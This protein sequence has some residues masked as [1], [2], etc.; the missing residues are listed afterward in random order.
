MLTENNFEEIGKRLRD[1]EADPPVEG[2]NKIRRELHPA[3]R[4][5]GAFFKRH[6]WKGLLLLVPVIT[7]FALTNIRSTPSEK[8]STVSSANE[9]TQ[10]E[11]NP[12][13]AAD[14]QS[15]NTITLD[16][17]ERDLLSDKAE[18]NATTSDQTRKSVTSE[19]KVAANERKVELDK[20]VR[21]SRESEEAELNAIKESDPQNVGQEDK[22]RSRSEV[23][24]SSENLTSKK[25]DSEK[26]GLGKT[27]GEEDPS[28]QLPGNAADLALVAEEKN[29]KA[30]NEV[31]KKPFGNIAAKPDDK[32]QRN[33]QKGN[34]QNVSQSPNDGVAGAINKDGIK[35]D[36]MA[37]PVDGEKPDAAYAVAPPH[38]STSSDSVENEDITEMIQTPL[39]EN[40]TTEVKDEEQKSYKP[41]RISAGI[42]PTY[43]YRPVRPVST[44]EVLVTE[45]KNKKSKYPERIGIGFMVG[46]AKAL[47]ENL[48]IDASLSFNR[49]SEQMSYSYATG[50]VDT[51]IAVQQPDGSVKVNPV[52]VV[53]STE[54][55][56]KITFGNI[57]LG[58]TYYFWQRARSRFNLSVFGGID[59]VVASKVQE[60]RNGSWIESG[61]G[62][63][64]KMN[65]NLGLSGGYNMNLSRGWELTINPMLTYYPLK[66]NQ[67]EQ[68]FSFDQRSYGLNIMLSK[69]F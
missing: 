41:W 37:S 8:A 42:V 29:D 11:D 23:V 67:K 9:A 57:R 55:K 60:Q 5:N 26:E 45:F 16:K 39:S 34:T 43:I 44:D 31:S 13:V 51:L 22:V 47:N 35:E 25:M 61:S 21:N 56:S 14:S 49:I 4:T 68:L 52:Y 6:W 7:Y 24:V 15:E 38:L 12:E 53:N 69:W 17:S 3:G 59:F 66:N 2:W 1:T 33:N 50:A 48:S 18:S 54:M 32:Q 58:A 65:Y 19:R 27:P 40:A 10:Q 62:N 28:G 20:T 64:D 30:E 63:I 46:G 36:E